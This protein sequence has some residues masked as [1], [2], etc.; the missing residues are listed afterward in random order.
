MN[1]LSLPNP[2]WKKYVQRI[3]FFD[4]TILSHY[5]YANNLAIVSLLLLARLPDY[6]I[7]FAEKANSTID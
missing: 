4:F 5:L 6:V 1:G 2:E 7:P 3:F